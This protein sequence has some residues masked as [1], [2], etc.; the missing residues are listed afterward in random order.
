MI[1]G[2]THAGDTGALYRPEFI[3][4]IRE[5]LAAHR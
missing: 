1:D 4:A 3:S 5:F 2:A